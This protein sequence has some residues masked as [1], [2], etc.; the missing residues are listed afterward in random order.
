MTAQESRRQELAARFIGDM[1]KGPFA[2][3]AVNKEANTGTMI[4]QALRLADDL[5]AKLDAENSN[6]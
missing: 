6:A 3:V 5:I 1:L 4:D 2:H